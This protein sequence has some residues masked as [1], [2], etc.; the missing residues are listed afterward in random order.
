MRFLWALTC[1]GLVEAKRKRKNVQAAIDQTG[2]YAQ[3]FVAGDG[4]ELPEG[5]PWRF[6]P[7]PLMNLR[8]VFPTFLPQ[9]DGPT[10][11]R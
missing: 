10:S 2:R 5:G 6:T 4:V 3:A 11:S 9:M 1:I 7:V 8:F